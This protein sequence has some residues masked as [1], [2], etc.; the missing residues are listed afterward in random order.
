MMQEKQTGLDLQKLKQMVQNAADLTQEARVTSER[1]RDYYDEHQWTAEEQAVLEKR[2][3]PVITINR[4]KRKVDAMVGLEQR[5]RVDPKAHPR[6]PNDEEVADVAT[7]ALTFVDDNTRFDTKRSAAFENMIVEG[8]GGVEV[9]VEERRGKFE[10][11][12][13][14]L[15]WEEIFFDPHSREKDFSDAAYLGTYK[16]M[17][18][19][20]AM[21]MLSGA[22]QGEEGE[23]EDLLQTSMTSTE[24]GITYEDRPYESATFRWSDKRKRRVR[25]ASMYYT[26]KGVW[27]Y[28]IFVSGGEVWHGESPYQDEDGKP[29]CPIHLMT[30]YVDRENRRY[31]MVRSMISQQDEINKRRSKLLHQ[32]NSRQTIGIKGAID[33]VPRM[34]RELAAPDGHVEIKTEV[35]EDAMRVGMRPFEVVQ[36]N[37]Q[38]AGQFSLLQESKAEIDMIGPN[39]S[40]IGQTEGDASGR[41]IMAQQQAGMAEL[42]PLYDSLRDWTLRVYRAIW[43][44]IRQFWTEERWI[45]VTDEFKRGNDWIGVNIP[46]G[47]FVQVTGP[48]GAM[49]QPE[50]ENVLAEMDVD[51]IIEDTPDHITLQHEQFQQLSEMAAQGIPIPPEMIIK[52]SSLKDKD[53]V[54]ELLEQQRQ[55]QMQAQMQQAAQE[56]E[57]RTIEV[58]TKAQ[59]D[60]AAANKDAATAQ[61]TQVESAQ[62]AAGL[63]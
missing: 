21:D 58:Q 34:K 19:D 46:T 45:R 24:T 26:Y 59:R 61:K 52:A 7:K 3:Q 14:R 28:C 57:L 5:M 8:F 41:A 49:L 39:P 36:Q 25:V 35:M 38:V 29:T 63:R 12:I 62:M 48:Q 60:M 18:V 53:E 54:L 44:R 20:K 2:K 43:E 37:D 31:G 4:I 11:E 47:G 33:S 42:A 55:M 56:G 15:R 50:M 30:G 17:D 27:H 23:L 22:W 40:L 16:W 6:N 10:I 1:D 32:L 9:I 13:N 51:I